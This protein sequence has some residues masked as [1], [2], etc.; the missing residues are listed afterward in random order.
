MFYD[1][2]R[3]LYLSIHRYD[4]GQFFPGTG[5]AEEVHFSNY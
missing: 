5:K 2:D 1:D 4:D 3:V